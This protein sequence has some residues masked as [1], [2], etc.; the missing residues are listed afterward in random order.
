MKERSDLTF[1]L[2]TKR[3]ERFH[4]SLPE[5]WGDGHGKIESVICGGESGEDARVCDFGW[6]IRTMEQ[7]VEY[8][9]PFHFKQTGAKFRKGDRIYHIARKDQMSQAAKAGVDYR[10]GSSTEAN[11]DTAF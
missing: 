5:D 8:E 4:V 6:V 1:F 11:P 2:I 7:C 10:Y 9:V 3:I